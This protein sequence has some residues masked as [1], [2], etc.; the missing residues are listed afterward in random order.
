[1]AARRGIVPLRYQ[2][3]KSVLAPPHWGGFGHPTI[4]ALLYLAALMAR[5][6]APN[7]TADFERWLKRG[8]AKRLMINN[9]ENWLLRV[10][11]VVVNSKQPFIE[12]YHLL[13]S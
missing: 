12:N 1:L 8:K 7:F 6:H 11:Y 3:A 5:E 4:R 13:L 2:G 10:T 9:I